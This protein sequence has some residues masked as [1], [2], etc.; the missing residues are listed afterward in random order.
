MF[1]TTT[2]ILNLFKWRFKN[3]SFDGIPCIS[4]HMTVSFEI[5]IKKPKQPTKDIIFRM[6]NDNLSLELTKSLQ[7]NFVFSKI[8][9]SHINESS[10][11]DCQVPDFI[12]PNVRKDGV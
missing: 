5:K 3:I 6:K 8:N 1:D 11:V 9:C 2:Y 12:I 10:C 7:D 4:D